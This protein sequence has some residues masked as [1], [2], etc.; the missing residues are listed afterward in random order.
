MNY[1]NYIPEWQEVQAVIHQ[2]WL[3]VFDKFLLWLLLGSGLPV[4]LYYQSERLQ[5]IIPF[6]FL[7]VL[8]L[9]VFIKIV[10]E[11]F[12]WYNDV[13]IITDEAVYALEWSL[14]KTN[15][16]SVHHGNI[17]GI[18]ID[19]NRIWDTIFNKWDIIIKKF[20]DDEVA[21]L[22]A[23]N[24]YEAV[25]IIDTYIHPSEQEDEN[26]QDRFD[27]VMD[28]LSGVV[29]DFLERKW[30]P[31][32]GDAIEHSTEK[33]TPRENEIDEYTLDIRK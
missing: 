31:N 2:H 32:K 8:L 6:V 19:R 10:Y 20:W 5:N 23:Y 3:V 24:P 11:L 13:W 21:I 29:K 18:E 12:N 22:D 1:A 30:Y 14:L 16:E 26:E 28:A 17:E 15:V 27:M 7:E 33:A 25:S 9:L 4:F